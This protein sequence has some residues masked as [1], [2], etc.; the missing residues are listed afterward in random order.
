MRETNISKAKLLTTT[1][2]H[3]FLSNVGLDFVF[4]QEFHLGHVYPF[5]AEVFFVHIGA[6]DIKD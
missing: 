1:F 4:G 3:V 2:P 6:V 5:C